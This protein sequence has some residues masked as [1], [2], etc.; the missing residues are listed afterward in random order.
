M[1]FEKRGCIWPM[2]FA[3]AS[4]MSSNASTDPAH[5]SATPTVDPELFS[6]LYPPFGDREPGGAAAVGADLRTLGSRDGEMWVKMRRA[7]R[8]VGT[9]PT[10]YSALPAHGRR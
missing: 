7:V 10:R 3:V 4:W 8:V 2:T 5:A 6:D 9:D 1:P